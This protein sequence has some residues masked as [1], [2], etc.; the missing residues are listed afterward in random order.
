MVA[1]GKTCYEYT[2]VE[3]SRFC[4]L[5]ILCNI[6]C[7]ARSNCGVFL[8]HFS[9]T[10]FVHLSGIFVVCFLGGGNQSVGSSLRVEL[11]VG[12]HLDLSALN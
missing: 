3:S 6:I 9:G 5:R 12:S 8:L 2:T 7:T 10:F 1:Y 11:S 4:K